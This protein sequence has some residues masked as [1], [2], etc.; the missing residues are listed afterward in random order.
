MNDVLQKLI[1]TI[2]DSNL[3]IQFNGLRPKDLNESSVTE[4]ADH[5]CSLLK[6]S[7]KK[8]ILFNIAGEGISNDPMKTITVFLKRVIDAGAISINDVTIE[9]GAAP[10]IE[11]IVKYYH[12][13]KIL[14]AIPFN[15]ILRNNYEYRASQVLL[16]SKP[17]FYNVFDSTPRI[18]EKILLSF[19]RN[20]GRMHRVYL[21]AEIIRR[22]LLDRSFISAYIG[23]ELYGE[24]SDTLG[25]INHICESLKPFFPLSYS[26]IEYTLK[27]NQHLFPIELNLME[28]PGYNPHD[29]TQDVRYFNESYFSVVT[30]TKFLSDVTDVEDTQLDCYLFSEKTYKPIMA[31]HPFILISIPGSLAVLRK[32]GYKTFHPYIN[33]NYDSIIDDEARMEAIIDEV[34]RLSKFTDEEWLTWQADIR[35]IVEHNFNNLKDFKPVTLQSKDYLPS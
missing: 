15:I 25:I 34:E 17:E 3:V 14:N 6:L 26:E 27:N 8:S 24:E 13:C 35:N 28:Q 18:K 4:I 32:A 5:I 23:G 19:N 2:D 29:I 10:V 30:E 12:H 9:F 1:F 31:K 22:N 11:N 21:I 33:E 20:C 16:A 7:N